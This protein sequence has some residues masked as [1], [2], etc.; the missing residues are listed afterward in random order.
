M[1]ATSSLRFT[2]EARS[3]VGLHRSGNEDS[4]LI[5][6]VLI[7]VADGMG[8][9]AGGEVAS[10]V[11][12]TTLAQI[13]PLLNNDEMDS[14]SLE[15]FLQSSVLDVDNEIRLTAEA[16]DRLSGMGT[17]LTAIALYRN[18]AY[19]LHTGDSRA[20]RLRGKEFTQITKDHSVVQELIDAGT[21]TEEEA[22][23]HPQRSV[24]TNVL[25]G[26][27]NITPLLIEYEVKAGDK[28]LLCSD[29]LS[30]VVSNQ[31]IHK[32]LDEDDALSKL[33]SLTYERGAPD[34]VTVV[35]A[36]AG[37]GE[38]ATAFFGAAK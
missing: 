5:N 3:E 38:T 16:D 26:H 23:V 19:V 14:E 31:E 37:N 36:D 15:D 9:H 24:L 28:F 25:M 27:G 8:G 12:I 35:I 20:Y 34:N 21:I 32:Y 17:T 13:L 29:G 2:A 6:G 18:K 1:T 22:A 10:K 7:A 11:A 30:N 4:A 33:I